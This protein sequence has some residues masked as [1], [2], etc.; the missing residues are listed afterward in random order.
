MAQARRSV[1]GVDKIYSCAT[2]ICHVEPPRPLLLGRVPGR[3]RCPAQRARERIGSQPTVRPR[4]G[5]PRREWLAGGAGGQMCLGRTAGHDAAARRQRFAPPPRGPGLAPA[6]RAGLAWSQPIRACRR[7]GELWPE[8][9]GAARGG[10]L[11]KSAAAPQQPIPAL[12][13]RSRPRCPSPTAPRPTYS[14]AAALGLSSVARGLG[15]AR[16]RQRRRP[17]ASPFPEGGKLLLASPGAAAPL[18]APPGARNA[19]QCLGRSS[20]VRE[21]HLGPRRPR[22]P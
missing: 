10:D 21:P 11:G 7:A 5:G 22:S 15:R 9:A 2:P 6:P 12:L 18:L 1:E 20:V 4:A 8:R 17:G 14:W 16:S 19:R 3:A 13:Q